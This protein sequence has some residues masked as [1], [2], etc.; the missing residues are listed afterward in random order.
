MAAATYRYGTAFRSRSLAEMV[1]RLKW[2]G[3][4][5]VNL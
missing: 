5:P 1:K 4:A 3:N 2:L